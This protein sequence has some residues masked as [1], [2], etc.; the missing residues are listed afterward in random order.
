MS[1]LFEKRW[2]A[3][4]KALIEGKDLKPFGPVK[5]KPSSVLS[6]PKAY[7]EKI[8]R[9][10]KFPGRTHKIEKINAGQYKVFSDGFRGYIEVRL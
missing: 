3:T 2:E 6:F 4:K 9:E 5:I 8:R 1:K 7:A 10:K